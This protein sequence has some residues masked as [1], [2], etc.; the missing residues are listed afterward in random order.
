ML[1]LLERVVGH[2]ERVQRVA[3]KTVVEQEVSLDFD[4]F[5]TFVHEDCERAAKGD[6]RRAAGL[7][8]DWSW[9]PAYIRALV[10]ELHW[11][12]LDGVGAQW[13]SQERFDSIEAGLLRA[14]DLG[15]ATEWRP[16]RTLGRACS[17]S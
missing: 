4:R 3:D 12:L 6:P 15:A 13:S 11:S 2:L 8:P 5:E 10:E 17:V 9:G 14:S 7:D 1:P 16:T